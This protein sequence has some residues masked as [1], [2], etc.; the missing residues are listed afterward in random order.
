MSEEQCRENTL[1][2]SHDGCVKFYNSLNFLKNLKTF[3]Y[4]YHLENSKNSYHLIKPWNS[5]QSQ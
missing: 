2:H 5:E 1:D 3:G 4:L